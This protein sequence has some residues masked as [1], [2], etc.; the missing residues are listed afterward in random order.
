[1]HYYRLLTLYSHAKRRMY[2][3]LKQKQKLDHVAYYVITSESAEAFA[4][5][6][7]CMDDLS[8]YD[9]YPGPSVT[10]GDFSLGLSAEVPK[11]TKRS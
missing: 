11:R 9:T 10:V 3:L 2:L 8:F 5:I 7:Q 4:F 6:A 1:M